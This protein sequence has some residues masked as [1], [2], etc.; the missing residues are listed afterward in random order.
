M[1]S[2]QFFFFSWLTSLFPPESGSY[3]GFLLR[4]FG[5]KVGSLGA[6]SKYFRVACLQQALDFM[7]H[8]TVENPGLLT[9]NLGSYCL[10]V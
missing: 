4:C 9:Y 1:E 2:N 5:A 10:M 8:V 7:V 3:F 6:V